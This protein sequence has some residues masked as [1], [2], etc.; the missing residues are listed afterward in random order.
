MGRLVYVRSK[1]G[2]ASGLFP[3][4]DGIFALFADICFRGTAIAKT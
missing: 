2:F 1:G 3:S 4:I